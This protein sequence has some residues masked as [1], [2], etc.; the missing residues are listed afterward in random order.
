MGL[1][2]L[3]N[4]VSCQT[5]KVCKELS[6][7][8]QILSEQC[9]IAGWIICPGVRIKG[10]PWSC[11]AEQKIPPVFIVLTTTLPGSAENFALEP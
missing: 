2:C 6:H 10:Q 11:L 3:V 9:V 5:S 4:S 7:S 1:Q 8:A